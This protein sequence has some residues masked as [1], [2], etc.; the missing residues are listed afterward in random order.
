MV[1]GVFRLHER[2][3][4]AVER[5]LSADPFVPWREQDGYS[6]ASVDHVWARIEGSGRFEEV[7]KADDYVARQS[8]EGSMVF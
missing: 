4:A 3:R 6:I 2:A 7:I 8:H 1:L 5:R